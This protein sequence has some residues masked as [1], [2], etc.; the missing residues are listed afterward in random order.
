MKSTVRKPPAAFVREVELTATLNAAEVNQLVRV[1]SSLLRVC[2]QPC[3]RGRLRC[4]DTLPRTPACQITFLIDWSIAA[5][6]SLHSKA[7]VFAAPC[8]GPSSL[9]ACARRR[10]RPQQTRRRWGCTRLVSF[11]GSKPLPCSKRTLGLFAGRPEGPHDLIHARFEFREAERLLQ[12]R[13]GAGILPHGLIV[14]RAAPLGVHGHFC[15]VD[16]AMERRRNEA[17]RVADRAISC[18][19]EEIDKSLLIGGLNREDINQR[20]D[21]ALLGRLI[22]K[23]T[24]FRDRLAD[25]AEN[26]KT[27]RTPPI[28]RPRLA[29]TMTMKGQCKICF[30]KY[31]T[32]LIV[33]VL[34]AFG[35]V[36][37][38]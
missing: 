7:I 29:L 31:F 11:C 25:E 22:H 6:Q 8:E 16:A 4:V 12:K 38:Q 3:F 18:A 5:R 9:L 28:G 24:P 30:P 37:G 15:A 33:V 35:R 23:T 21:T 2:G 27:A 14:L 13:Q 32:L 19:S 20:D 17:W 26:G 34:D 1:E 36:E 10:F